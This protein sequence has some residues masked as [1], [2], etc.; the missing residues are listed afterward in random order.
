M[1]ISVKLQQANNV[2]NFPIH[3]FSILIVASYPYYITV[4]S[5][6]NLAY[7]AITKPATIKT[8]G[9]G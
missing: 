3:V 1:M 9:E 7:I 8:P 6:D 5:V 4:R 2:R